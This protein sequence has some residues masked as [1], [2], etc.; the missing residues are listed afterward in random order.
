MINQTPLISRHLHGEGRK[1]ADEVHQS[2][3]LDN[4]RACVYKRQFT[5]G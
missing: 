2:T 4:P 1:S 5:V 3:V